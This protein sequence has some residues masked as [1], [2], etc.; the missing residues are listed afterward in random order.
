MHS[1]GDYWWWVSIVSGIRLVTLSNILLPITY[2]WR[3]L[4]HYWTLHWSHSDH[5]DVSNHQPHGCLLNRLFGRRSKK[6]SKLFVTGLCA[7]NSP[8]PVNSPHK[9]SV[10]RK[11][12][13]F[14]DVT[15]I[16]GAVMGQHTEAGQH[17]GHFQIFSNPFSWFMILELRSIFYLNVFVM[18]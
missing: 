3:S 13:P 15:M 4:K 17:D 7:G 5:D 1:A 11:M 12:F 8:G 6:T 2:C 9:G 16:N 14:E 18:F 10:T